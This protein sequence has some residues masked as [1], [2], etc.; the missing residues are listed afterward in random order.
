MA[1]RNRDAGHNFE[2]DM[3]LRLK[4]SGI[5]PHAVTAR[6]ESRNRDNQK[7]DLMNQDEGIHGRMPYD[8]QCKTLSTSINY[9]KLISELP[10]IS[11][12]MPVILHKQT[13]KSA[14]GKFMTK[15]TFA[16][17]KLDDW[18]QMMKYRKGFELLYKH[19][20]EEQ[21]IELAEFGL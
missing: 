4:E 11:G 19:A 6:A 10:S 9:P 17:M 13:Q 3:V 14:G 5:F 20:T 8:F 21:K 16:A 18:F 7:V 12:I 1:N 2:R 15:G